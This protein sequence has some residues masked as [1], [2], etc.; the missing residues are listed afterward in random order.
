M[1]SMAVSI[2]QDSLSNISANSPVSRGEEKFTPGPCSLP[3]SDRVL[4]AASYCLIGIGL[5]FIFVSTASFGAGILGYHSACSALATGDAMF[6]LGIASLLSASRLLHPVSQ[7]G[8]SASAGI[9]YELKFGPLAI[10]V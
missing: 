7:G 1:C 4:S 5:F 9:S 8:T 6:P 2:Q 10:K 3:A